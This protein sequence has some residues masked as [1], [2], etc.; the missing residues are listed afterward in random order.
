ME[1]NV[2][3]VQQEVKGT[4]ESVIVLEKQVKQRE[5]VFKPVE[6]DYA[7]LIKRRCRPPRRTQ[8]NC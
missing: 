1:K 2:A 4:E 8:K 7:D 5:T 3:V 6:G